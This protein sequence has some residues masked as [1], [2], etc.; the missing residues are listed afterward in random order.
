M[1]CKTCGMS[2][3]YTAKEGDKLATYV[4]WEHTKALQ[5]L[6]EREDVMRPR[7][8]ARTPSRDATTPPIG[9][10]H[11]VN[12]NHPC[13]AHRIHNESGRYARYIP[14][15]SIDSASEYGKALESL[16]QQHTYENARFAAIL[17]L[18]V[19]KAE[20]DANKAAW[21][22]IEMSARNNLQNNRKDEGEGGEEN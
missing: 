9:P 20:C 4:N 5:W 17:A 1:P 15:V 11:V 22:L 2:Y 12:N 18:R 13:L 10:L 21:T 16:R 8:A 3:K 7:N 6:K 19:L 14:A